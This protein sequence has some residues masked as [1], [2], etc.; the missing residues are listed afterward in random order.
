MNRERVKILEKN[1][2]I[3]KYNTMAERSRSHQEINNK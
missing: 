1:L 3:L 2:K